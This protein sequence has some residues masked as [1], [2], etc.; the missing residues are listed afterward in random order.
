[1]E[2]L[3][4]KPKKGLR[5]L[6]PG[7]KTPLA[8]E[9]ETVDDSSFW[10]RRLAAGEVEI[11]KEEIKEERK[12]QDGNPEIK[13]ALR[14]RQR[15]LARSRMMTN[16]PKA[17]VVVTNPIH[18]AIA[19]QYNAGMKAPIVVAKGAM[20]LADKIKEI[21]KQNNIPIVDITAATADDISDQDEPPMMSQV[22]WSKAIE[23]DADMAMAIHRYPN[24]NMIEIVSRKNRH[25]HEYALS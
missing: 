17:D 22:A 16:V 3:H 19:L 6:K 5:V 10:K 9:G 4:L 23:Y 8:S 18:L 21:A 15:Q 2:A 1:M 14:R 12:R 7:T 25:G 13:A 20:L 24:T 11:V